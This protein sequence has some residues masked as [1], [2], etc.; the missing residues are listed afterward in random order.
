MVGLRP[1][2]R[3]R[4]GWERVRERRDARRAVTARWT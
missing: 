2:L 1:M 3:S 4:A